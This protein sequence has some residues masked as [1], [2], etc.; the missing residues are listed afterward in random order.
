MSTLHWIKRSLG[1]PCWS[2]LPIKS[3][4]KKESKSAKYLR[5]LH[6]IPY[7]QPY[8]I[9]FSFTTY[10]EKNRPVRIHVETVVVK[11][12][13]LP[14]FG[15]RVIEVIKPLCKPV[16]FWK[17]FDI[18]VAVIFRSYQHPSSRPSTKKMKRT[19]RDIGECQTKNCQIKQEAQ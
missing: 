11:V 6:H 18:C 10:L 7:C 15:V 14:R 9:R 2:T 12:S 4:L 17:I 3:V 8:W 5:I 16:R 1:L 19:E 13:L